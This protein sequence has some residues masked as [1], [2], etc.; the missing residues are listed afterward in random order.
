MLTYHAY[1]GRLVTEHGLRLPVEPGVRLLTET[2]SWQLAHRVVSTWAKD[3]D[4]D[5][6][7][8]TVTGYLLT[9]AGELGEHLVTP[10]ALE[11]HAE[12]LASADRER[13]ARAEAAGRR[14]RRSCKEVVAAQRL[15]IALLPLLEAYQLRKRKEAALDFADQMSLAAQLAAV[16][17]GDRRGSASGTAPCC[18]TS[19]RTPGT[20]SA[21]CC[22]RCSARANRCRSRRWATRRR[23]STAGAGRQRG[24]PAAVRRRLPADDRKSGRAADQF[25]QPAGGA[26]AGE[27]GVVAAARGRAGRRGAAS[28]A[29]SR[30]G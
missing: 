26:G 3:L 22:G 15:R 1:A 25:P 24:E 14:C 10:E 2:A 9:L 19:T 29:G 4:T 30:A 6:V 12:E 16:P 27:R 7:P 17:R 28:A 23:R 13:A 11:A 21:C 8:A 5:K 18:S 20:R